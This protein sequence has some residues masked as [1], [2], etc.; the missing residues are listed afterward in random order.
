MWILKEFVSCRWYKN[1]DEINIQCHFSICCS[2]LI[3][4]FNFINLFFNTLFNIFRHPYQTVFEHLHLFHYD[5]Q[6]LFI[7][8]FPYFRLQ[9]LTLLLILPYYLSFELLAPVFYLVLVRDLVDQL[10][11]HFGVRLPLQH[12]NV[13]LPKQDLVEEILDG[14]L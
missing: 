14:F 13:A 2:L 3:V 10:T 1:N 7:F 5:F 6:L 12:L 9:L 8:R 11:Y 4:R